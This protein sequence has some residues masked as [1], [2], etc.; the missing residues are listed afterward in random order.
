MNPTQTPAGVREDHRTGQFVPTV[1][2]KETSPTSFDRERAL[3]IAQQAAGRAG[4]EHTPWIVSTSRSCADGQWTGT[5]FTGDR[6]D[7]V[8][9][10]MAESREGLLERSALIASAPALLAALETIAM[11]C[12]PFAQ[13]E[14]ALDYASIGNIARH[15]IALARS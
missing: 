3:E 6:K 2:G 13:R 9:H 15:A 8:A 5:I 10:V 14:P 4:A 12:G 7:T 1:D 11:Q